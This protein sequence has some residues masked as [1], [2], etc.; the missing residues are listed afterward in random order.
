MFKH[1]W[2]EER[3]LK[4]NLQRER[5]KGR[6]RT[7]HEVLL[8]VVKFVENDVVPGNV[9]QFVVL[10]DEVQ[11]FTHVNIHPKKVPTFK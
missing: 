6:T 10:A 2:Q 11:S 9:D 7:L 5:E 1:R 3:G 8:I 4:K